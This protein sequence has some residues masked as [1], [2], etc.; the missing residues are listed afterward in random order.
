MARWLSCHE[1]SWETAYANTAEEVSIELFVNPA[2]T[3]EIPRDG[4][5]FSITGHIDDGAA[6][7]C[8]EAAGISDATSQARAELDC[9]THLVV[10]G[11]AEAAAP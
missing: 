8:P 7:R 1:R 6:R 11:L 5:W 9:R 2:T 4:G 10:T 3:I